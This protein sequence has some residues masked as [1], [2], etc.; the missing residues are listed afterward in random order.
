MSRRVLAKIKC[1]LLSLS[2]STCVVVWIEI[3][4]VSSFSPLWFAPLKQQLIHYTQRQ[5]C[6]KTTCKYNMI[7]STWRKEKKHA[8]RLLVHCTLCSASIGGLVWRNRKGFLIYRGCTSHFRF[9]HFYIVDFHSALTWQVSIRKS[10]NVKI[11]KT[12]MTCAPYCTFLE[13]AEAGVSWAV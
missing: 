3:L 6:K 13:L 7:H 2:L 5:T 12:E 9:D 11:I 4:E 1:G 8:K 10:G